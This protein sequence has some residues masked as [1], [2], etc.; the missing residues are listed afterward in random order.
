MRAFLDID[1]R[2]IFGPVDPEI[3]RCVVVVFDGEAP[4]MSTTEFAV[5]R[6]SRNVKGAPLTDTEGRK[7]LSIARSVTTRAGR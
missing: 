2:E 6:A 3:A 1:G 7:I 4:V 5:L